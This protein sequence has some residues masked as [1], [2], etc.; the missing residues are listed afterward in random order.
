MF[1]SRLDIFLEIWPFKEL[2]FNVFFFVF[3]SRTLS[4]TCVLQ[5][6][7]GQEKKTTKKNRKK[8]SQIAP[9]RSNLQ[10]S[11]PRSG[12]A[13]CQ[14]PG[15]TGEQPQPGSSPGLM[16]LLRGLSSEWILCLHPSARLSVRPPPSSGNRGSSKPSLLQH[17]V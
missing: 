1:F 8:M 15:L 10:A 11:Q 4:N 6:K 12:R 2:F 5:A 13:S 9:L 16:P 3:F 17:T 7:P 14:A